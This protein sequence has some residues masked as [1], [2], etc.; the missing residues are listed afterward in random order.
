M[1]RSRYARLERQR[2][3]CERFRGEIRQCQR[4]GFG[5]R[6]LPGHEGDLS[7]GSAGHRQELFSVEHPGP[8][9]LVRN[10]RYTR[11]IR[12]ARRAGRHHGGDECG[13]LFARRPRIDFGRIPDLRL[14]LA[15][16]RTPAARRYHRDPGA[17]GE[18]R[19]REFRRSP[20]PDSPQEHR[21]CRRAGGLDRCRPG[22]GQRPFEREL[23]QEAEIAGLEHQG[24]AIGLRLR[25][26]APDLPAA[27][28]GRAHGQ[29]ARPH[30][31]RRQ[32]GRGPGLRVRGRHGGRVVSDHA[33]DLPDG[34]LQGLLRTIPRRSQDRRAQFR[35]AAGRG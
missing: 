15:A 30:H 17:P 14:H 16:Q 9:H 5:Q 33:V 28:A 4:H 29:D 11:C 26:A 1:R 13:N 35:C 31:D 2:E 22:G 3:S 12:R 23:R 27:A 7:H 8:A 34:R 32:Y 24:A 10:P 21:L 19:E 18:A 20:Q 25:Q 6:Q